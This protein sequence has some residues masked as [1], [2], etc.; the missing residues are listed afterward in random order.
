[1][2]QVSNTFEPSDMTTGQS[3]GRSKQN[4]GYDTKLQIPGQE[5]G[6]GDLR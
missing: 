6:A 3:Q 1:M 2:F 5:K 4:I